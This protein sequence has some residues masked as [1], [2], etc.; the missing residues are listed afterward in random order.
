MSEVPY[1]EIDE[2]VRGL[3]RLL[4]EELGLVTIGSCGGH[5]NPRRGQAPEGEFWVSIEVPSN[6]DEWSAFEFLAW[7][8]RDWGRAG[9]D[10]L[11]EADAAPS[12]VNSWITGESTLR[13]VL[14]G[15]MP[16]R[17]LVDGM[18][19]T[20]A[21]IEAGPSEAEMESL[22]TLEAELAELGSNKGDDTAAD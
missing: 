13:F 6:V 11:L 3:V 7:V 17:E 8:C 1:E 22:A 18:R 10:L 4:N 20:L 16:A 14:N 2:P 5:E 19:M 12:F 9:E 21:Q 15:G